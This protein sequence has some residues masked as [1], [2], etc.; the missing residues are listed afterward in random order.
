[1]GRHSLYRICINGRLVY[2]FQF[3][4][5]MKFAALPYKV[6]GAINDNGPYPGIQRRPAHIIR[7][8]VLEHLQKTIMQYFN[9][10]FV[11]TGVPQTNRCHGPIKLLIQAF[12]GLAVVIYTAGYQFYISSIGGQSSLLF[13]VLYLV[14]I[15]GKFPHGQQCFG[16]M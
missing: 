9:G 5:R 3:N 12:L 13:G 2:F 15:P 16:S 4:M 7:M 6:N 10:I 14:K 8:D 1:M 11:I